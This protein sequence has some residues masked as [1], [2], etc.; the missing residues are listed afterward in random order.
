MQG[1]PLSRGPEGAGWTDGGQK[2]DEERDLNAAE[3]RVRQEGGDGRERSLGWGWVSWRGGAR[4]LG[5]KLQVGGAQGPR[6]HSSWARKA[7]A[8]H[9]H[10]GSG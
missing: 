6:E 10:T 4:T 9:Y 8:S 7:A 2:Q 1:K 5:S 3:W